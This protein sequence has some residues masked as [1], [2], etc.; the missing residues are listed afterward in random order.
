MLDEAE[1][2]E[3]KESLLAYYFLLE[4]GEP[5]TSAELGAVIEGWFAEKWSCKLDFEIDDALAKLSD[6]GLARSDN[7]H[8]QAMT[9]VQSK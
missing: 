7:D 8:W 1:E 3:C 5:M 6:L 9:E 2:S 4:N